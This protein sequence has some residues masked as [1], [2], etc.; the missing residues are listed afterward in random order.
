MIPKDCTAT[1]GCIVVDYR[2]NKSESNCTRLAVDGDS[3]NYPG[4]VRPDTA[5]MLTAKLLLNS[6]F[7]PPLARCCVLDIKDF[8]LN[9]KLSRYEYMSIAIKLI[10][11]EI[12]IQYNLLSI[13]HGGYIY[14]QKEKGMSTAYLRPE[15]SQTWNCNNISF[16][17][18]TNHAH[19]RQD[20]GGIQQGQYH[21]HS[22]LMTLQLNMPYARIMD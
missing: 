1:Y 17:L 19:K 3:V 12:I 10:P 21:L 6:A 13:A 5:D 9:N 2:P 16:P 22:L 18:G 4:T 15:S 7:S 11:Q 20:C 14:A 8:Y